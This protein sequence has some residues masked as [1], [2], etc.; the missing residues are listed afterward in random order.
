MPRPSTGT[1]AAH[2]HADGTTI[3]YYLRFSAL[4]RRWR[5]NVGTNLGGWNEHRARSELDRILDQVRRGTWT[6][7]ASEQPGGPDPAETVQVFLSRWLAAKQRSMK[8]KGREDYLWRAG[9]V[10]RYVGRDQVREINAARVDHLRDELLADGLAPRSV[11]MVLQLL[12]QVLDDAVD[13]ELLDANP[14][15]GKRRRVKEPAKRGRSFLE[16]DH[17]DRL[18]TA[19]GDWERELQPS[20][21]FG[22]RAMIA[23]LGI[24]GLRIGEV[25]AADR[26][27]LDLQGGR[28]HVESKTDAGNRDV[29][30]T[31]FVHDEMTAHL[32][33]RRDGEPLFPSLSGDRM[34]P[35]NVRR[36]LRQACERA[37]IDYVT[38]HGLRR[39]AISLMLAAGRDVR[40]VMGQVGHADPT[41]TLSVYAQVVARQR[42]D[43]D[44]IRKL[45]VYLDEGNDDGRAGAAAPAHVVRDPARLDARGA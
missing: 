33:S 13:Y 16:P 30:L 21:R 28:L 11:N 36:M 39:T 45:T 5:L 24:G 17:L 12:A 2:P 26:A 43:R 10:L 3:S 20:H 37:G 38:P 27:D 34:R 18:L 22:R 29:E 44:L 1:V 4:R 42:V 8:P 31:A 19:A 9:H 7:P 41:V 14:A 6:P 40:F 35:E 25:L 15:R 32:A 23:L